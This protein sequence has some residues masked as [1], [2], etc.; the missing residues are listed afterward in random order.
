V[1]RGALDG[2]AEDTRHEQF[3]FDPPTT[4]A[5]LAEVRRFARPLLVCLPSLAAA[6]EA[7]GRPA[8]LLDR[9]RRLRGRLRGWE[10]FDLLQPH[11]V[12]AQ[13]DAIF[14]DP[15]FAGVPLPALKAAV[16]LLGADSP[17]RPALG[18]CH[19]LDRRDEL[20]QIFAAEGLRPMRGPLGYV[21]VAD[22]TQAR[23]WLYGCSLMRAAP[24]DRAAGP[25]PTGG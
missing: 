22:R 14:I 11:L 6:L 19:L 9:D 2:L 1:S 24:G 13:P 10:R 7:E 17:R 12:F 8:R 15:P 16:E 25:C 20:E 3:F 4:A 5:L 21:S 18:I 23:I